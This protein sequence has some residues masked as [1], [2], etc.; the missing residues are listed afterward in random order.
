MG[1]A[2]RK[3]EPAAAAAAAVP[4]VVLRLDAPPYK[5]VP[6]NLKGTDGETYTRKEMA[7]KVTCNLLQSAVRTK[8]PGGLDGK[9]ARVWGR[10]IVALQ[11]EPEKVAMFESDFQWLRRM[12]ADETLRLPAEISHWRCALE[13]YMDELKDGLRK[14]EA[15]A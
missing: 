7:V 2:K 11:E 6:Q 14:K 10:L 13:D 8:H 12:F 9:D 5:F 1:E 3:R 4:S 15:P